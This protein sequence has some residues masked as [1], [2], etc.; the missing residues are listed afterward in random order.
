LLAATAELD[1]ILTEPPAGDGRDPIV[2]RWSSVRNGSTKNGSNANVFGKGPASLRDSGDGRPICMP[3][4]T[5][6]EE[7][8]IRIYKVHA[9]ATPERVVRAC[10][11]SVLRIISERQLTRSQSTNDLIELV[12][13]DPEGYMDRDRRGVVREDQCSAI[14]EPNAS[15]FAVRAIWDRLETEYVPQKL[16][17][18]LGVPHGNGNVIN[19]NRHD[20]I[21][22]VVLALTS[23][24]R[25]PAFSYGD[26][27]TIAKIGGV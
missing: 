6:F 9:T 23:S 4:R 27:A 20:A 25:C 14:V 2:L 18:L 12:A 3:L 8:T 15:E 16:R 22:R 26:G 21:I 11:H 24:D 1:S 10:I 17:C 19:R 5:Y 7:V 13:S